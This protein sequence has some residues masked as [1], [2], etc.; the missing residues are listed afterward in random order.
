MLSGG[1][2]QKFILGRELGQAPSVIVANQ[3]TWGLDIGAVAFV[4]D[5]LLQARDRGAAVL[6]IS[7]DLEEIL[8]IADRVAV[9]FNGRLSPA[10]PAREWDAT[11]IGM[12]MAG[13]ES[14]AEAGSKAGFEAGLEAGSAAGAEA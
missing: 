10:R 12:A 8:A 5:Q 2:I 14:V 11:G 3:P 4:H 1:N 13:A 6:L 7:E 9:I